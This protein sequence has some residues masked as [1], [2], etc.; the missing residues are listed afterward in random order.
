MKR[1]WKEIES[2]FPRKIKYL[3]TGLDGNNELCVREAKP[4]QICRSL[5]EHDLI[6]GE[7]RVQLVVS[8]GS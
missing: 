6:M 2:V 7:S 5:K 1:G 4:T 8:Q 3:M